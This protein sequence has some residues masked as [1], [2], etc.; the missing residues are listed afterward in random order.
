LRV[1]RPRTRFA[2]GVVTGIGLWT[3]LV[4]IQVTAAAGRKLEH[5]VG[6]LLQGSCGPS[7]LFAD[8]GRSG[9][10]ASPPSRRALVHEPTRTLENCSSIPWVPTLVSKSVRSCSL[11]VAGLG[12]ATVAAA[13]A[14]EL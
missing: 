13:A 8:G 11:D 5:I 4:R 6:C 1:R 12:L 14:V 2:V 3:R 9:Q 7:Q 10:T